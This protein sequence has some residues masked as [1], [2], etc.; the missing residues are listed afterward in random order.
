[1][2]SI[3]R[4]FTLDKEITER[5]RALGINISAAVRAAVARSDLQAYQRRPEHP[6][7]FWTD[8]E[9]WGEA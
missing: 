3:R 4:T 8:A 6:D 5:A 2:T 9:A 1:M 7:A